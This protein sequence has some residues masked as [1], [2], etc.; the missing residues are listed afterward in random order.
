MRFC[1]LRAR[2]KALRNLRPRISELGVPVPITLPD[3]L[4]RANQGRRFRFRAILPWI[5][6]LFVFLLF[7]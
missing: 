2:G 6:D 4:R 3:L 1:F 5:L 7:K